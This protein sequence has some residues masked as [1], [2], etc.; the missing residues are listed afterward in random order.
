M[1]FLKK[2]S[3]DRKA[4][5]EFTEEDHSAFMDAKT[6]ALERILGPMH[7]RVGHALIPFQVGG[8]VHMYYFPNMSIPGVG[9]ATQDLIEPDG[10]GPLPGALGTYELVAVTRYPITDDPSVASPFR[11]VERRMCS[12]FTT[13][14][15]FSRE[16]VL[17]PYETAEVPFGE[18]EPNVC[19]FFAECRKRGVPFAV[20]GRQ[21]GLLLV[22]EVHRSEMEY[23]R[24]RS[25]RELL[26]RL[27]ANGVFPYSDMGRAPVV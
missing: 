8:A 25:G 3:V 14:G 9:M 2:N 18:S 16:A 5:S 7:E 23:A 24:R 27:K 11:Q 26:E 12:I 15:Y 6:A 21:H 19:L 17:N 1:W 4:R 20:G 13:L 22:M 10:S